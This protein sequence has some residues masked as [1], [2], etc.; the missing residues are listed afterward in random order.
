MKSLIKQIIQIKKVVGFKQESQIFKF[1]QI[2]R[3]NYQKIK[4]LQHYY[5]ILV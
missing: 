1:W 3:N 5:F 2:W 4:N